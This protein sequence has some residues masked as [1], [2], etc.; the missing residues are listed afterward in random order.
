[1]FPALVPK[2]SAQHFAHQL[3]RQRLIPLF[4]GWFNFLKILGKLTSTCP[5]YWHIRRQSL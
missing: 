5:G 3:L 2:R 4:I 1:M